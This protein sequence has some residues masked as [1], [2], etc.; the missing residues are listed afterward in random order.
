MAR[1]AKRKAKTKK[2]K[3]TVK[4]ARKR[5]GRRVAKTEAKSKTK[6]RRAK[7]SSGTSK[8][9]RRQKEPIPAEPAGRIGIQRPS[10]RPKPPGQSEPREL[11]QAEPDARFDD[12]RQPEENARDPGA[13]SEEIGRD[14][15]Y[16]NTDER[17]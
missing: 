17:F 1:K 13:D 6:S 14:T 5:T 3:R 9:A 7:S 8:A 10:N 12:R 4:R 11:A 16:K 15:N 2:K